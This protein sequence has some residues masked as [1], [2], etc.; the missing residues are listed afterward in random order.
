MMAEIYALCCPTSGEIRYIGK[1]NDS[2]KRLKSH[3]R[4]SR[5]RN[6]PVYSWMRKLQTNGLTPTIKVLE[7]TED[8]VEAERRLISEYRAKGDLLNL[9]DGGDE[10]LCSTEIRAA[11]GRKNARL[12]HDNPYRRKVWELK[13]AMGDILRS[14]IRRGEKD[15]ENR[16]RARMR[17]LAF[18]RPDICANWAAL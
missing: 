15:A 3:L 9:A 11:N 10:P 18:K 6:T 14:F 13:K 16:Q 2:Q 7:I 5:R 4:D 17:E 12:V 1:A 8:W